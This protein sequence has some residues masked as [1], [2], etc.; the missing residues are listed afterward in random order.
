[1]TA[2]DEGRL[3]IACDDLAARQ[4]SDY[5]RGTPGTYFAEDHPPLSLE[6]AYAVQAGVVRLRAQDRATIAGYKL[7]CIGAKVREQFGM[8]G[9]IR[10]FLYED[11]LHRSGAAI[12]W[13]R[14][15]GLAIEG[16]MAVRLGAEG[17]IV[18]AFPV[19]E[20]H[21]HVFRAPRKTLAELVANNG[22]NAGAVLPNSETAAADVASLGAGEIEV[23]LNGVPL[24]RGPLWGSGTPEAALHWLRGHLSRHGLALRPGRLVLTGTALGLHAVRPGDRLDVSAGAF[25]SVRM[26]VID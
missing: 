21:N 12:S 4:C 6:E 18:S 25:G 14:H 24:E 19:I 13:S 8:D 11:E 26:T 7:G 2:R 16:E 1:M 5:R 15:A 10:G 3:D 9:P 20:P 22:L 17:E 23:T